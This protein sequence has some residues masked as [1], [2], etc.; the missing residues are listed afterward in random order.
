[1]KSVALDLDSGR[2]SRWPGDTRPFSVWTDR[3]GDL[4]TLRVHIYKSGGGKVPACSLQLLIKKPR[5]RD[6]KA[7]W[8]LGTFSRVPSFITPS[9][10][11]YIG[12]A[13][14]TGQAYRDAL[15]LDAAP[16]NDLPKADFIATLRAVTPDTVVEA[17]F[18]Y[19]LINSGYRLADASATSAYIG[20]SDTGGLLIRNADT[21]EWREI[22]VVG[23]GNSTGFALG[24]TVLGPSGTALA[25]SDDFVRIQNGI[26]QIKNDT[27]STWVNVILRGTGGG[28]LALGET[29]PTGFSLSNDRYKV[30][31]DG[32][33][34]IRNL[35]T[36]NWH[37]ARVL[38]SGGTNV[39]ALGTEYDDTQV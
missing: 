38:L 23:E 30:A 35:T 31:D 28:T 10:L 19:E 36:G 17:E 12:Q 9:S 7:L 16:G 25:I 33:L 20:L 11:A 39:L 34:L 13:D 21:N 8:D 37:E 3:Y 22:T 14:V 1:M 6:A 32:R 27:D 2:L 26:L 24:E 29:P 5:R 18:S 15:K 4:Y